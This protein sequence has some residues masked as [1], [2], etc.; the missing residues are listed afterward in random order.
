MCSFPFQYRLRS[1]SFIGVALAVM[2]QLRLSL[3]GPTTDFSTADNP[4]AKASSAWSR[5]LT[6]LYLPVFNFK[7]LLFPSTLSF[8]WGMDSIPRL[9]SLFDR[10]NIVSLL[11]YGA[12]FKAIF[13]NVNHLK[14][15]L[16]FMLTKAAEQNR[17]LRII[18]K[19]KIQLTNSFSNHCSNDNN[20]N[21]HS[22]SNNNNNNISINNNNNN[23]ISN[24]NDNNNNNN[25]V[26]NNNNVC[27]ICKQSA[28][29][30]HSS[31]CRAKNN[32]N[33]SNLSSLQCGCIT[34]AKRH[35]PSPSPVG[36]NHHHHQSLIFST[37]LFSSSCEPVS[38]ST[39]PS[40]KTMATKFNR[41]LKCSP[42]KNFNDIINNNG[43][44]STTA[45]TAPLPPPTAVTI[46]LSIALLTLPF[47]PAA[48]LFFYVGF[49]VAERILYLPS[50]GY[51]LLIGL[52]VSKLM[53]SNRSP[54]RSQRKR[55]AVLICISMVLIVFSV[56]TF[57]RNVDW[58]DEESLY[59]SAIRI[60]PPKGKFY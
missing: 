44:A 43:T 58:K 4:I 59:R 29:T 20:N 54:L 51:C 25:S 24:F 46:L 10:R 31:S 45:P 37:A 26:K 12:L 21:I 15:R 18:K 53:D 42:V 16:H 48:N 56:K 6:F 23:N 34:L 7:L 32:N 52:G 49:V 28:N 57:N 19:R 9:I 2:L 36:H 50:V 3:P 11:F 39:T 33:N 27:I 1:L 35:S 60:N 13:V 55:Y 41:D 38:A 22:A 17:K 40:S 47:L 5:F 8:D 14:R 30:R